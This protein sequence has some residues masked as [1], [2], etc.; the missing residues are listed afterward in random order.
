M[1]F[2]VMTV[3]SFLLSYFPFALAL[4]VGLFLAGIL[5]PLMMEAGR[6]ESAGLKDIPFYQGEFLGPPR[7]WG[8]LFLAL[9][10]LFLR[11]WKISSLFLWPLG[12]EG[13]NG[14]SALEL[15]R[16]WNW[17]F[18]YTSGQVPPLAI[19]ASTFF[20]KLG[21]GPFLSLWFPP[22]IASTLTV[23][24]GTCA[25]RRFF[26]KSFALI[27]GGLL[28]FS[29]WPLFIGRV[30]SP[31]VWVPGWTCGC[32]YF[33]ARLLGSET[34]GS[35]RREAVF[36]GLVTGLGPFTFT[37]WPVVAAAMLLGIAAVTLKGP[38]RDWKTFGLFMTGLI[39]GLVPFLTAVFVEGYGRHLS[40]AS[41][42]SHPL[43]GW[44]QLRVVLGYASLLGWG[45][46]R[47]YGFFIPQ[48]GGF[49][50]PFLASLFCLG[51]VQLYRNR[52]SSFSKWTLFGGFLFLLPGFLST[53]VEGFRVIQI[54]PW[55]M[56]VAA[57]GF[58]PLLESLPKNR[59]AMAAVTVLLLSLLFDL[60][61]L[62][63]PYAD[64]IHHPLDFLATGKSIARYRAY[65]ILEKLEKAQ[66]PGLVLGEWD[67][68]ADRTMEV[69]SYPFNS[70]LNPRL[71]PLAARWAAVITDQHYRPFLEKRFPQARWWS[72][73]PDIPQGQNRML[74]VIPLTPEE[75]GSLRGWAKADQAFRDLNW[76]IDH[77][78][79]K[80]CLQT[81]D[82]DLQKDYP[83]VQGD[84]FLE[85]A[86]WEK[87]AYFYY[88]SGGYYPEQLR[89]I[90]LAIERGYPAAH[91]YGELGELYILGGKSALA[92]Q[93]YAEAKESETKFPWRGE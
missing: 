66:G 80:A 88:Y 76:G 74:G 73:D 64:A 59:R 22:A 65:E 67:I 1:V 8:W 37:S 41:A 44:F 34:P 12:D 5:S 43:D 58:K 61:R 53:G 14:A 86:Y 15:S 24:A 17:T 10:V 40:E 79:D 68:P 72:L 85:S 36:L 55:L 20:L 87:A 50:N 6:K 32:L 4:K 89:A 7:V 23:A 13:L 70:A 60:A 28:A 57:L 52:S 78:D 9:A 83:L 62:L 3:S 63:S 35:R 56:A 31:A 84:P 49:L 77:V 47:N 75:E 81:V 19:W 69:A 51:L 90:Q 21:C 26:S 38:R 2:L 71:N 27:C 93:A 33:L 18:F 39:P 30:C 54:M 82:Q 25:A 16:H 46:F 48:E 42:W 92:R 91:L 11:F 45:V 29:Y